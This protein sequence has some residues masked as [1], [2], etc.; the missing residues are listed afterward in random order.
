MTV[1]FDY[2]I[3]GNRKIFQQNRLQAHGEYHTYLKDEQTG[4]W[5][6]NRF[7][8]LNGVWKFAYGENYSQTPSGFEEADFDCRYWKEILVPGHMQTQ[9]YGVPHYTN[10]AYPWDGKEAV[11]VG[12]IPVKYNPVGCYVKY[13]RLPEGFEKKNIRLSFQGVESG[14]AVWLNGFY[15]GYFENSFDPAEFEITQY[16]TSGENKLAVQVFQW[17]AGSWCEDQD[18]FRFSG[19]Y[20]DVYLYVVPE[21]HLEDFTVRALPDENLKSAVLNLDTRSGHSGNLRVELLDEDKVI[22]D[23]M[24][25]MP[26]E[27]HFEF[28]VEEPKLWSAEFPNLYDLRLTVYDPDKK[29]EVEQVTQKVGFRRFEI[30]NGIMCLNGKRIVFKGV[31]RHEFSSLTGRTVSDEEIL[32]DIVTMKQNNINAIRTSHYPDDVRIYD[33]C[34]QYG[35]YVLAENN[36]ETHGTWLIPEPEKHLEKIIP[37]DNLEWEP[38][39]LDRVNSCYQRDK[40]HPSIL[41]WSCG[42]ESFGGL[43]I[44]NMAAKFHE[45]DP[46]R[47]V[48]YEG[49]Y[50]DGRYPE[51]SDIASQMYPSVEMIKEYLKKDRS[52]P[53]ICCEYTH[54]MGNSCGAMHKYT[55]LSDMDASYQGGF[56]WDYIDQ[57]LTMKNRYGEEYQAYGGDFGDRPTD[58][59]F[60]GNGIVY[61]KDRLPSPKMQEVKFNYQN[62]SV[63]PDETKIVV[64]N[65]HLFTNTSEFRCTAQLYKNGVKIKETEL[66]TDVPPLS[67]KEYN[68]PF[69]KET[70]PG[71]YQILVSFLIREDTKWCS[72]G[73]EIAFGEFVYSVEEA[74]KKCE[75]PVRVIYGTQNVGVRGDDFEALFSIPHG[76]LVSYRYGGREYI[77]MIPK[78]NFWRAPTDNDAGNHMGYRYAQWKGAGLYLKYQNTLEKRPGI[79]D[80]GQTFRIEYE[81]ELPT[82]L[83]TVCKIAYTVSGDGKISV[84]M[85]YDPRKENGDMPEFGMMF[86]LDADLDQVEWYGL[87]PEE[88]YADR[89]HGARLGIFRNEVKDNMASYIIPQECGNHMEVRYARVTDRTGRGLEFNSSRMNFSALPY[90]PHEIECASHPYELPPVHHTVVRVALAQM[91]IGGDDSWGACVHPEY[92]IDVSGKLRFEFSFRGI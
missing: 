91:G 82:I 8:S 11:E 46:D 72:K 36:L 60:S 55:E 9:G 4:E 56:I 37:G 81:Y 49:I 53:F 25:E 92:L 88:T 30:R 73:H 80:D 48:H 29:T 62:V 15:V 19:I 74:E 50:W 1:Q 35:L 84:K 17:T 2:S 45:L 85:E 21:I 27:G 34:D 51:S 83:P 41:I 65:K 67:L 16:L 39:L 79:T 13:F 78:P 66:L 59:N 57:T 10:T 6:S 14:A 47:P 33:L 31:N 76:G 63:F 23:E 42:N 38:L 52:K 22:F 86:L 28:A 54:A 5:N 44:R 71:E 90:T 61:G 12:E 68:N 75:R 89:K 70:A 69:K 18:F 3:V 64:I 77:H 24:R 87:G 40:N 43:V 32:K 7:L 58:Y 20:R 26:C